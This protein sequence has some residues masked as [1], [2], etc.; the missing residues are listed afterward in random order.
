M[1][2]PRVAM[3]MRVTIMVVIVAVGVAFHVVSA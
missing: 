3:G 2:V 1:M